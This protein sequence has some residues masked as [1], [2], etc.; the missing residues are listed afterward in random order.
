MKCPYKLIKQK[1]N[2]VNMLAC[3]ERSSIK[4]TLDRMNFHF[5]QP[6][7]SCGDE[8]LTN[9]NS[10]LLYLMLNE[11]KNEMLEKYLQ[12]KTMEQCELSGW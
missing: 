1:I 12:F 4:Q 6:N 8:S 5:A 11:K 7:I 2:Y 10:L 9:P 3:N